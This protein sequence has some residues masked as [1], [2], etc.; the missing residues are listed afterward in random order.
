MLKFVA[1]KV[2]TVVCIPVLEGVVELGTTEKVI[3]QETKIVFIQ[4][5]MT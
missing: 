1:C 4:Q 2:Q 3:N 5:K